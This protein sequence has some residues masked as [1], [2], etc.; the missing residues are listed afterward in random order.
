[1]TFANTWIRLRPQERFEIFKN[2]EKM[3]IVTEIVKSEWL[4][5]IHDYFYD[6]LKLTLA[7]NKGL[8]DVDRKFEF[9]V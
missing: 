9:L 7:K 2:D 5:L 3:E 8:I 1:M 6:L 4:A